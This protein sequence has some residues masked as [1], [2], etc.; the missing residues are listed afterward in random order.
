[1]AKFNSEKISKLLKVAGIVLIFFM[2]AFH[3]SGIVFVT[4]SMNDSNAKGFLKQIFPPLFIHPSLQLIGLGV[5]GVLTFF[6]SRGA[7]LILIWIAIMVFVD[8]LIAFYLGAIFPGL[9]LCLSAILIWLAGIRE[10]SI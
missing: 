2:A 3:I 7:R 1:M 5:L 9:L 8:A 6:Y 4:E 10:N